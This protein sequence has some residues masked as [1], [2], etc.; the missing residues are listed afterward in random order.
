MWESLT[1]L[2]QIYTIPFQRPTTVAAQSKAWTAQ[3]LG[4]WVLFS[5]EAWMSVWVYSVFVLSCVQVAAVRRADPSSKESYRL[6]KK[7]QKKKSGQ[8][9]TKCYRAIDR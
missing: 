4:S 2:F 6:C 5:P 9:P 1:D 7:I 8:G 3:T